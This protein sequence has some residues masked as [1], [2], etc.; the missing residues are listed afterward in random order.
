MIEE[1]VWDSEFFKRK[2]GR[3]TSVPA[4]NALR[5]CLQQAAANGYA[6]LT[7]RIVLENISEIQRLEKHGFYVTDIGAVWERKPAISSPEQ[8]S[9][10][11]LASLKDSSSLEALC[12]GLFREGRFFNDPFF[13]HQEAERL[14]LQW[15][16]NSLRDRTSRIFFVEGSGF[17]VCHRIKNRGDIGLIGVTP[18]R[19]GK[20]IG[21]SLVRR[22][23]T[24]FQEEKLD[25][26]TVRTQATNISAMNFY[27]RMGFRI[28]YTDMTMGLIL[29]EKRQGGL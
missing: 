9:G 2:I 28:K 1:A 11:R 23:L 18:A 27:L 8:A 19:Q 5:K 13:T 20:G 24:W 16:I 26:V 14:Y 15:V 4:G 12:E 3:L 21:R 7:C 17:V 29:K 10:V 6:Y 22:A 25:N